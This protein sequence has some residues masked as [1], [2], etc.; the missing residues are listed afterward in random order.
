MSQEKYTCPLSR[1][2]VID[3]YFM[4]HRA[5]MIDIAAFLDRVDR[6]QPGGEDSEDF[7]MKAFRECLHLLTDGRPHRARRVLDLLSD[8]TTE[9]IPKA[10]TQGATG[11]YPGEEGGRS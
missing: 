1:S 11:A 2:E 10:T 8:P 4:E 3:T 6:A 5:K 7:R 9:P